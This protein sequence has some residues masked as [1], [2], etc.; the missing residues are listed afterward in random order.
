MVTLLIAVVMLLFVQVVPNTGLARV[1]GIAQCLALASTGAL[2]LAVRQL[3]A[4]LG[5]AKPDAAAMLVLLLPITWFDA[6]WLGQFYALGAAPCLM[7]LGAAMGRR[8]RAM[9]VWAGI[10]L[11]LSQQGLLLMPFFLGLLI[12]RRVVL[13]AWPI[14]PAAFAATLLSAWCAGWPTTGSIGVHAWQTMQ[15]ASLSLNAPNIWAVV[16]QLPPMAGLPLTGLALVATIGVGATY[17]AWLSTQRY[18]EGE[19][20]IA[21]ALLSALIGVAFVSHIDIGCFFLPAILALVGA[22]AVRDTAAA[23]I[24]GCVQAGSIAGMIACSMGMNDLAPL[25]VGLFIFAIKDV[26]SPLLARA[27]NDNP[28]MART[29]RSFARGA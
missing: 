14:M 15:P 2:V 24:A 13:R 18:L 20:L 29:A 17:T 7:A 3:L 28:V 8:H 21:P 4:E 16:Q 11:G 25:C 12:A 5:L 10:A 6:V 1:P 23:R 19:A 26:A 9:L 27:A 22:L